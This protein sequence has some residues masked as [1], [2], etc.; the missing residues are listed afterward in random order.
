M[1]T[2]IT[3][4]TAQPDDDDPQVDSRGYMTL[5]T[6]EER[7]AA[8]QALIEEGASPQEAQ[9]TIDQ[10]APASDEEQE[11]LDDYPLDGLSFVDDAQ[12]EQQLRALSKKGDSAVDR[13]QE[14][15]I[16]GEADMN[17]DEEQMERA[18]SDSG[19]GIP[20][21]KSIKKL[22]RRVTRGVSKTAR[23]GVT[24]PFGMARRGL[25]G[26]GRLVRKPLGMLVK[27]FVPSRD[28]QKA[29]LVKNSYNKM[30]REHANWLAKRSGQS[31][32]PSQF[33]AAS[34]AWAKQKLAAKGLPLKFAVSGADV[35]GADV[36]GADVMGVWWN[37][38]TWFQQK[39]VQ[40]MS[41]TAPERDP[42]GPDG[43]PVDPNTADPYAA[44]SYSADPYAAEALEEP[45]V[46][47]EGEE[48]PYESMGWNGIR[49]L[50]G[51]DVLGEDSLGAFAAHVLGL[52]QPARDNPSADAIVVAAAK[53][54]RAGQAMG[55]GDL[56]LLCSAAKEGNDKAQ[57]LVTILKA[58][59]AVVSGDDSGLDPW[60]HKLNPTYWFRSKTS[61]SLKDREVKDWKANADLQKKL[62][63]K[64]IDLD[65]A[66]RTRAAADAVEAAKQQA[67]A[68]D[69]Q[70]KAIESSLSGEVA[71]AFVGHEKVMAIS[72]VVLRALERAGLKDG[73]TKI[74]NKAKRGE[75][76]S[77]AE[78]AEGQKI[79]RIVGRARVVHGDLVSGHSGTTAVTDA[80]VGAC[81][82]GQVAEAQAAT[83][84]H[85]R[86]AD[87]LAAKL[88]S[89]QPLSG[90]ERR[91]LITLIRSQREVRD[92]TR[93]LISGSA[94]V[95]SSQRR[96]WTRASLAGAARVMHPED[97]KML[98][99]IAKLAKLGNPR[100]QKALAALKKTGTV[101]GG[102][103][104]GG[105]VMGV[106]FSL[107]KAFKYATAPIWLPAKGLYKGG[108]W[109][110]KKTG[111]I[112]SKKSAEQV[113]LSK[114]RAAYKRRQAAVARARAADAKNEA[115]IR[116]QQAIADAADAEAEAADAEAASKEAA[117]QT[118]EF[119]AN[120]DM[121]PGGED[122][123]E[124]EYADT[125]GAFV[126]EW[127]DFVGAAKAKKIVKVAA[128]KTPAGTKIR[129]AAAIYV[130]AKRGNKK[131]RRA[132]E[133]IVAK[134]KAGD[135]QALRDVD[136][137]KAASVAYRAKKKALKKRERV[138][139][140]TS[141]KKSVVAFQRRM[142]ARV[143]NKLAQTSRRRELRKLAVVE[144]RAALGSK[145]HKAFVA[146]RV[147]DARRGDKKARAQ[148]Q[149]MKLAR[150][151]RVN[152]KTRREKKNLRLASK[153]VVRARKGNPRAVRQ[154]RVI[155]A[156]ARTGNPNAKRAVRRMKLA[157]AV[158]ATVT[159]GTVVLLS[160]KS[161]KD[162]AAAAR[163]KSRQ[164]AAAKVKA[165]AGSASR[166]E[167]VAGARAA[168]SIGDRESSAQLIAA[169]SQAPSATEAIK[170][171]ATTLAAARQ[172]SPEASSELKAGLAAAKEGDPEAVKKMGRLAAAQTV[173]SVERGE[174]VPEA[175]RDAI[176]LSERARAGDPAAREV[177]KSATEAAAE[178]GAPPEA[179]AAAAY[180]SGAAVLAAAL[181]TKPRAKKQLM[182]KVNPPV[183]AEQKSEAEAQVADAV[184]RANAGTISADEGARA[185]NL[186]MRLN[187]PKVAAEISAKSPPLDYDPAAMS[188]LP[189]QPLGPIQG[190]RGVLAESVRALAFATRDPLANYREGVASRSASA[191]STSLGWSPFA[192]FA[193][194]KKLAPYAA[195]TAPIAAVA[196]TVAAT[197]GKKGKKAAPAKLPTDPAP[198]SAP[199]TVS[200]PAP[201]A[202]VTPAT[203]SR[204][205]VSG[206][207]D[208]FKEIVAAALRSKTITR[209]DLERA[210][211]AHAGA[212]SP[213]AQAAV[214]EQVKKFLADKKVVVS[215]GE[216]A[217]ARALFQA[218][219]KAKKMS[220][221][222]FNRAVLAHVGPDADDAKKKEFGA[223]MLRFLKERDVAVG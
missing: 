25:R 219:M 33:A 72:D 122:E 96:G 215:G 214:A 159:T 216:E 158:N 143:A 95:G 166:E 70:L 153:L 4:T 49:A 117:M 191:P 91:S 62:K 52:P 89:G 20:G 8:Y 167:L 66:E 161:K 187:K 24:N 61:R 22:G 98:G 132:I 204:P 58:K 221:E 196:A 183:A 36:L 7:E 34:K 124:G 44:D 220:R 201:Q 199:P 88:A 78:V 118:K 11:A 68:T 177:L 2:R 172:G 149:A 56:A 26:A 64:K 103:F 141:R 186:A 28:R 47:Y 212:K 127:T 6:D 171:E 182:E 76:L 60:L 10:M 80:I 157:A 54:L 218:A 189:D 142:E 208:D 123:G 164:V 82:L 74:Y 202:A 217:D 203:K 179:T 108:K 18:D 114:M 150:T 165:E 156:A 94:F 43:Q 41:E 101:M 42:Y 138:A 48:M 105:D 83:D 126:G 184:A 173:A 50:K 213:A 106:T 148:V 32:Q 195:L 154:V 175:M 209:R 69:A 90:D 169:A 139:R 99:A 222:D 21:I 71:G 131:S 79:A 111:I 210:L 193:K 206:G 77:P 5:R 97:K 19:W 207:A 73:A 119:E 192:F 130:S 163:A 152:T 190:A 109:V 46:P 144:R 53:K 107:K 85:R 200:K 135:Q 176:N 110:G 30:W 120:P 162:P 178:P 29:T 174:P 31:A 133:A 125:S 223:K 145:K 113:R 37:P 197:Q 116:A 35:L 13:A 51:H 112:S 12:A 59:G 198:T 146:K 155:Q 23:R 170:R 129:S 17:K 93:G 104:V 87:V 65:Q 14:D 136:A 188:S 40:V 57:R 128:S 45:Y 9:E 15:A 63:V 121:I 147:A 134:A 16:Y 55:P 86:A 102:D 27:K 185:A 67:A 3:S 211:R 151:V 39:V 180:A 194:L 205:T 38:F 140:A 137:M 181:A 75:R 160:K 84:R 168:Q 81:V 1:T 92:F 115:E 100:A